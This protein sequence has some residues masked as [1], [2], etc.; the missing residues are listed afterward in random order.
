MEKDYRILE[1]L[2]SFVRLIGYTEM[3]L[4]IIVEAKEQTSG[5]IVNYLKKNKKKL[6]KRCVKCGR[7]MKWSNPRSIC[8]KCFFD[9]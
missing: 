5:E 3:D 4:D 8:N 1:L 7:K 6:E 2:Y 9:N